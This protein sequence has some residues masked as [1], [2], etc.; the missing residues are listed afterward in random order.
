[1]ER[2][3]ILALARM[4]ID[5]VI[6]PD[7]ADGKFIA[8]TGADAVAHIAE[9]GIVCVGAQVAGID[10]NG[11][12]QF[13]IKWKG[14]FNVENGVEFA[15]DRIIVAIMRAKIALA[16]T[17]HGGAAAVEETFINWNCGNVAGVFL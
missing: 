1:M 13:A 2:A 9:I 11:S 4:G 16:E 15:A 12:L 14:I 10:K 17:A 6:E 8:Q 5:P 7:W 3:K